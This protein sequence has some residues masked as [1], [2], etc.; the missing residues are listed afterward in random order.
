MMFG[1]KNTVLGFALALAAVNFTCVAEACDGH[2]HGH[3]HHHHA[4]NDNANDNDN[5]MCEQE[6]EYD[7]DLPNGLSN[8]IDGRRA[9]AMFRVGNKDFGTLKAFEDS[10]ARCVSA[11]PT[12]RQ[13][14]ESDELLDQWR[15]SIGSDRRRLQGTRQI[16]VYFHIITKSNQQGGVVS[17]SQ[18]REQINVLNRSFEGNFEFIYQG[19]DTTPNSRYYTATPGTTSEAQMK[20]SLRK[21]GDNALNIY[22]S[23]PGGGVLGWATFPQ[24]NIDSGDGIVLRYD[25]L[26]RGDLVPFNEGDTAVH[27][28]GHWLGLYHTF[29]SGCNGG[30]G[31]S[32]TNSENE[33][34]YGCPIGRNVSTRPILFLVD[35]VLSILF[36]ISILSSP[37]LFLVL[38]T[39]PRWRRRRRPGFELYGLL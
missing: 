8:L 12:R 32:D 11:K 39:R 20:F 31:I 22:T 21:G 29:Q 36:L 13:L 34:A 26:P 5:D 4:A 33:P 17:D 3:H 27:E 14:E 2:G 9:E 6:Q 16:P 10:G 18:I 35:V 7:G 37:F 24:S 30:D 25:T 19:K 1:K 38:P 28:V 23:A 15:K